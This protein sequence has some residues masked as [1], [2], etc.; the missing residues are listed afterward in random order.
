M[1]EFFLARERRNDRPAMSRV[2]TICWSSVLACCLLGVSSETACG[3]VYSP[4]I[5]SSRT[6]D[7]YSAR[8]FASHP[9]WRDLGPEAKAKAMFDYLTDRESGLFPL[10][11]GVCERG[12]KVYE[13]G[14]VRDPIKVLNV[15][16]Y[17]YCD[18]FGP[19]MAGLW[20]HGG[21]GEARTVAL[22]GMQHVACEVLA[23]PRWRYLDVDLRGSFLTSE[24]HLRSLDEARH[25]DALWQRERGPRFFPMDDLA[26][27]HEQ[28]TASTV[29]D[30]YSVAASG[31]TMDFVMRRGESFTRW[32]E[33]Q[34]GRWLL[35]EGDAKQKFLQEI[36][37]RE[38]RGP[39][40]KHA[41]FTTHTHGNGR[42]VYAPNLKQDAADFDDGAL[43]SNNLHVTDA[44]LT[45]VDPGDGWAVFEVRSPYVIVPLVGKLEDTKDDKEASVVE[46]DAT[47][48]TL[49]WSPDY[50][51]SWITLEPKQ[52][53]AVVDLTP[54][55]SGSYGYL[56]NVA[57]KGKPDAAVVRSL[58]I[59][60]WVQLAPASLPGLT[61][62]ENTFELKT[63]DHYGL[64][65]R[66][67][68][69]QPN[70]ADENEFLH[71]LVRAP[72]EFDPTSRTER[73]K[74]TMIAR[75]PSLPKTKIAW[76]SAG[77]SFGMAVGEKAPLPRNAIAFSINSPRN[78]QTIF[79]EDPD[80][81]T[82]IHRP[83]PQSHWHYN[84]DREVKL[85]NRADV[86]YVEYAAAPALNSYRMFAHCVDTPPRTPTPLRVTH[87][88][89]EAGERR[90]HSQILDGAKSYQVT[91]GA[92]PANVSI[93]FSVPGST[94]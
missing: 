17:G 14:L 60:T 27:L 74:G 77:A 24:G 52:W 8:T 79:A 59:T 46:V 61:A 10:G 15:Y 80:G 23:N 88:W 51:D 39:K 25:D 56:L 73:A 54:Q 55:V 2:A 19:V 32:W 4:R 47:G 48:A 36:L 30:R 37:E 86:I 85:D 84:V 81:V 69:V 41:E 62:G 18:V 45:L 13:F 9:A 67:R 33:P 70:A 16:G 64:A 20:E 35:S 53:P 40:S 28:F 44:G 42:F 7:G 5:V 94:E 11:A 34:G 22:P 6:A 21:C 29:E 3:R 78:F 82:P 58:K 50:G 43:D 71:H 38:P 75:L 1:T 92:E 12:D 72:R 93:E 90:E 83:T 66:V 49:S 57:L 89:T 63:G 76:F 91:A 68:A 26:K 65:T 87:V 31:H